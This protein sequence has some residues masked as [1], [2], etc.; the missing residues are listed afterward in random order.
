MKLASV[1][2]LEIEIHGRV[3]GL[4]FREMTKRFASKNE[5]KGFVANKDDGSVY[6]IAQGEK[7]KLGELLKWINSSPGFSKVESLRYNWRN[8]IKDY[9][10]FEILR[11]ENFFKEQAR[12]FLNLGKYLLNLKSKNVPVHVAIIPD[13]NRRWAKEKGMSSEIGHYKSA[14]LT[15]IKSLVKEADKLGVRYL[16]VWGFSTENWKRSK[17]EIEAIFGLV[18]SALNELIEDTQTNNIKIRHIGR[19][20]R[21]PKNLLKAIIDAE[22]RSEQNTGITLLVCLDYGGREELVKAVN[23]LVKKGKKKISEEDI[24]NELYTVGIPDVDFIIRTS[25]E[26][27]V[28]GFMPFQSVYAELYFTD[29]YFPDFSAE[30]LKKAIEDYSK[31]KRRFGG[32]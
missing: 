4:A 5:I 18:R 28:S 25:G 20:D 19:K 32:S 29:K 6:L 30:D 13:G 14:S 11:K 27:R 7:N 12:N 16:S 31:R 22:K 3:Q 17:Q 2:E 1:R 10:G 24:L 23:E 9:E 8:S 15:N 26:R 21:L